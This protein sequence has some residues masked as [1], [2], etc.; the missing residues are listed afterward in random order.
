L[1]RLRA[2]RIRRR[3]LRAR[4]N[5]V[6]GL[7]EMAEGRFRDAEK[8]LVRGARHSETPLAHFLMAA[9]AAQKQNAHSRRDEYLHQA[10]EQT[11]SA[12]VAVLL[13]Q[14]ELQIAHREYELA[15]ATLRR[16]QEIRPGHAY[17]LTLLARLDEELADWDALEQLLPRL[18]KS[19]ALT[20]EQIEALEQR[21]LVERIRQLA[22][23]GRGEQLKS[24]W[25]NIPRRLRHQ[26]P[27][28][29]GYARALLAADDQDAAEGIIR[30]TLK[31]QWDDE[32]VLAYGEAR[33]ATPGKQLARVENWLKEHGD[34]AALLLTAGRLCTAQQLWGKAQKDIESSLLLAPR[35][36]GYDALGRLFQATGQPERA[37]EAFRDGLGFSL[38]GK[39]PP[40]RRRVNPRDTGRF[41][42]LK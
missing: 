31:W 28:I 30:D 39:A 4:R 17:G 19:S 9:R 1:R 11:P 34:S 29:R 25:Q 24:L 10:Y 13:T 20:P 26:L 8:K 2:L 37:M 21:V 15:Q 14:A 22:Q 32:L 6:Q 5:L 35:A 12:T 33:S 41:E 27:L 7:T 3:Q 38:T 16:L 42:P 18:R 23:P 40:R 36:A